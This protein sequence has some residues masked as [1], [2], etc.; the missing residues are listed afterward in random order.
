MKTVLPIMVRSWSKYMTVFIVVLED[1]LM[2]FNTHS[3][4]KI[5]Y[6]AKIN[7]DDNFNELS[8]Q[9]YRK[10][11]LPICSIEIHSLSHIQQ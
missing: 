6:V 8:R 2:V 9:K 1:L 11:M 7:H 4:I 10:I 3:L 5:P